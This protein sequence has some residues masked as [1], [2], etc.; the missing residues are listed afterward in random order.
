MFWSYF[1]FEHG[2]GVHDGANTILKQDIKKEYLNMDP[3][4]PQN[5]VDVVSFCQ[6]WRMEEH[7][8][9]LNMIKHVSH[10]FHLVNLNDVDGEWSMGLPKHHG[11]L[12]L[13]FYSL[14]IPQRYHLVKLKDLTSFYNECMD[15]NPIFYE[16]K[17]H[18][19][20]WRLHTMEQINNIQ[21]NFH[22]E[23]YL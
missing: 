8:M 17:T 10:F 14:D 6:K 5:D 19:Q 11:N 9:Y 3:R 1:G 21:I 16:N 23:T 13:T 4:K 20:Q 12:F 7:V 2:K 15:D 22:F 18:V